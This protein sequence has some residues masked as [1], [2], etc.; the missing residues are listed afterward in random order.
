MDNNKKEIIDSSTNDNFCSN[1][2]NYINKNVYNNNMNLNEEIDTEELNNLL[3]KKNKEIET[4][5]AR[6]KKLEE[7]FLKVFKDFKNLKKDRTS[8]EYYLKHTLTQ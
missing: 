7:R 4:T 1:E 3:K 6:L 2:K 5:K 8:Y